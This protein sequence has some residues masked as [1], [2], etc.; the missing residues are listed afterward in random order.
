ML[1]DALVAAHRHTFDPA[2]AGALLATATGVCIGVGALLGW[3]LGNTGYG[4]LIG[5]IL[6]VPAGVV[7]VYRRFRG[8]I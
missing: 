5:A 8:A 1:A 3:A 4:I 7:A 2:S 6:G